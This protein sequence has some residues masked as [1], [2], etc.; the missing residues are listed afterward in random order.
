MSVSAGEVAES[1]FVW[2]GRR[3]IDTEG[4]E[5]RGGGAEGPSSVSSNA[6][7][8]QGKRDASTWQTQC[9]LSVTGTV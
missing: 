9:R 7:H 2:L 3:L 5:R 6:T 8:K 1:H 4:G